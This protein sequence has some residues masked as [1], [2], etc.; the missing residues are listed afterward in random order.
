MNAGN[1]MRITVYAMHKMNA[2]IDGQFLVLAFSWTVQAGSSEFAIP[3][4]AVW[5]FKKKAYLVYILVN[6]QQWNVKIQLTSKQSSIEYK[7]W[8]L[9]Q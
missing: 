3:C 1:Q 2:I 7:N 6:L 4:R 9:N 5:I 8:M